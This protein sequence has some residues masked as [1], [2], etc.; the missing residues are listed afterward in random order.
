MTLFQGLAAFPITPANDNGRLDTEGLRTLIRRLADADVDSIGLL[1]STG[2][3]LYLDRTQ[4]RAAVECAVEESAGRVP[5]MAGIG[6]VTTHEVLRLAADAQQA[7]A[8]GVLLAPVDYI[9]LSDR[10]V[11]THYETV[12]SA[13]DVP[14]C[15]YNN[16]YYTRFSFSTELTA[17]LSEVPGI[18]AVKN[19]APAGD[20]AVRLHLAALRARAA[21][22]FSCGYAVDWLATEALL[23][24]GDAWYSVLGGLFPEVCL[25]I[26]RAAQK[27][28]H[29]TARAQHTT[30]QPLWELFVEFGSLRVMYAAVNHLGI[31]AAQPPRPLLPLPETD[32][33]RVVRALEALELT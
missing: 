14:L 30:L 28:D 21:D 23:A 8:E 7:G 12:A 29:A 17:R 31:S 1:G 27:G 15:I 13:L 25:A 11:L 19:P 9:P 24:G 3:Y 20:T 2:T 32:R 33:Q 16:P 6:A 5:V 18:T 26:T 22:G 4:R 10:E